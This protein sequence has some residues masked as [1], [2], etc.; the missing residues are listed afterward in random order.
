MP[1]RPP[2]AS[3][4]AFLRGI[5]RRAYVLLLTQC[6]DAEASAS[7]LRTALDAFVAEADAM[8]L[9]QWPMRFWAIVVR[10][11]AMLQSHRVEPALA[12]LSPGPRSALLLRLVAGLDFE[13]AAQALGAGEAAYRVALDRALARLS[14]QGV[15]LEGLREQLQ[16]RVRHL[17]ERQGSDIASL[18]QQAMETIAPEAEP[19]NATTETD[20]H[21][22]PS[23]RWRL[24]A[25]A[26]LVVL[27]LAFAA[28]F[29]WPLSPQLPAGQTEALPSEASIGSPA[30]DDA[31]LATDPDYAL[32][33]QPAADSSLAREL[34]FHSW[35][36]G[37]GT[38]VVTQ[39]AALPDVPEAADTSESQP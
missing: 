14:E 5:E 7:A 39:S 36:A 32:L 8:P 3:L 10:Q 29:I 15:D 19:A 28:S 30:V 34:A 27:L 16:Q 12:T 37:R 4:Q 31:A 18:R 6:G 1:H 22:P 20:A 17:S 21:A 38:V 13:H 26:S 23:P 9:A 11:P 24:V 25:I 33:A 2:S 35:L